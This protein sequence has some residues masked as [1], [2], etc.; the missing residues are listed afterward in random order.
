MNEA[1]EEEKTQN[2]IYEEEDGEL[3]QEEEG[4]DGTGLDDVMI[5]GNMHNQS[6]VLTNK[7]YKVR[8]LEGQPYSPLAV[9]SRNNN[10]QQQPT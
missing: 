10:N 7:G 6:N 2:Y 8:E 4:D 9:H 5:N 3:E 1:Y